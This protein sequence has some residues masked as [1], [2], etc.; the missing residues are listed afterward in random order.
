VIDADEDPTIIASGGYNDPRRNPW[1]ESDQLRGE[2]RPS[3]VDQRKKIE[4]LEQ[5]LEA[6]R[7]KNDQEI[8]DF[9]RQKREFRQKHDREREELSRQL[10]HDARVNEN[11]Q[12]QLER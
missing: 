10:E 9:L 7:R 6:E 5:Q 11:L 4:Q 1:L 12:Q 8:E 3:S 2:E